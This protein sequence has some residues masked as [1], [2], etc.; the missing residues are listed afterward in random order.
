VI[1]RQLRE[2]SSEAAQSLPAS[3]FEKFRNMGRLGREFV[4]QPA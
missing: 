1:E 2:L 3:R 4:E